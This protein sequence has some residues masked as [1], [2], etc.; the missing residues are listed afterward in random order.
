MSRRV[1][2]QAGGVGVTDEGEE[3]LTGGHIGGAVRVGD[4]VRRPAGPWTP[5]VHALLGYLAPRLPL[6]P[7]VLGFDERGREVLSYL[8]SASSRTAG[9]DNYSFR[10][11]RSCGAAGWVTAGRACVCSWA[12]LAR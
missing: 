12:S 3:R 9:G 10:S 6:V 4:T 5:A 2:G 11:P 1:A 7:R 8:C